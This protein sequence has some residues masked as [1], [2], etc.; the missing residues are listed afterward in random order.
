MDKSKIKKPE[1]KSDSKSD[2]I[3]DNEPI[4]LVTEVIKPEEPDV[5]ISPPSDKEMDQ[6]QE[7]EIKINAEVYSGGLNQEGADRFALSILQGEISSGRITPEDKTR[8]DWE[9]IYLKIKNQ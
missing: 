8:E 2:T 6:E 5:K 3:I 9:R 1:I 4:E 7:Q